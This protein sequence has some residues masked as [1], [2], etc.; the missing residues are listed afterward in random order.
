MET[1]P[2]DEYHSEILDIILLLSSDP[3]LFAFGLGTV[4]LFLLLISSAL[5]SGAE[6]A[7]FS[8]NH[9]DLEDL[10]KDM[11]KKNSKIL[12]LLNTPRYL[13]S[14]I[15]I[16][17]NF[18]NVSTIV[19][20]TFLLGGLLKDLADW[21]KFII[22]T[23][24]VTFLLVLFGEV[25]PKVYAN[26][27]N[28]KLARFMAPPLSV[29]KKLTHFIGLPLVSGTTFIEKR[30]EKKNSEGTL[31]S[32]E[33]IDQAIE[34]TVKDTK[35]AKQEIK[36]LKSIVKFGNVPVKHIMRSRVDVIAIDKE[37]S[38][39]E[40][41]STV[42]KTGFSRIPVYEETLDNINGFLYAKDLL[43]HLNADASFN[44]HSIL[45]PAFFVPE[46]KK[47][48]D[49]LR[50]FQIRRVHIAIVVDEYGG[51]AG[52]VTLEDILEEI[53]GEIKDEFDDQVEMEYKKINDYNFLF[54]GKTMLNDVCR[55][56]GIETTIFDKVRG[57]SDSLAG[58][59]LELAGRIPELNEEIEHRNYIFKIT[60]VDNRRIKQVK[61]TLPSSAVP[62]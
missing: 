60:A 20:S 7:Y 12:E 39:K 23:I 18:I 19:L 41:I 6:V 9:Q 45:R 50:E 33:D 38:F 62:K 31:V 29:L 44:W 43:K 42:K 11:D 13:L 10:S 51:T 22:E 47:I 37:D 8:L 30:M 25:A 14:T 21:Q 55:L 26:A 2:G 1:D 36:L 15:L 5:I 57:D 53:I 32:L 52:L 54:E 61:I 4:F 16:T 56:V 28:L 34:L 3:S 46:T 59:I 35:G 27:N 58:L 49:L 17:N 24:I 48:D 40:I